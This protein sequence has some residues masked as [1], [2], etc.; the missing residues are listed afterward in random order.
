MRSSGAGSRRS[1]GARGTG[2]QLLGSEGT[3]RPGKWGLAPCSQEEQPSHP[4]FYLDPDS[5][6]RETPGGGPS[7]KPHF[8]DS[9][10]TG[11]LGEVADY[12]QRSQG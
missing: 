5:S 10:G 1:R 6:E 9:S 7:N 11:F 4:V 3:G 8:K 2:R 12:G